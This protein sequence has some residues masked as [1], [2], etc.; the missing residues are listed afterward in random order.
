MV[1]SMSS[2]DPS[3]PAGA[4]LGAEPS[5]LRIQTQQTLAAGLYIVS[6][7]I[8]NLRDITLRALDILTNSDEILAEDTRTTRR[9]LDA[10]G[11]KAKLTPYHDHNGAERRP[12]ILDKLDAGQA[13]ALVSD[14]GTPLISDPGYKLVSAVRDAGHK[15]IPIPGASALLAALVSSGLPSDQFHFAGFPPQKTGAR[16]SFLQDLKSAQATL[17]FYESPRRLAA[18]LADM[19]GIL[20]DDRQCIVAR[21]LTK[22]FEE[23]RSGTLTSLAQHYEEA[24][25]PKGEVVLLVGP[26]LSQQSASQ[27]DI[28]DALRH[29][30]KSLPLKAAA[31]ELSERFKLPKRDLYQRGLTLKDQ[32]T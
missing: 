1:W 7:P 32:D 30:L 16:K 27:E 28:D 29:A 14:A 10:Y 11:I 23:V 5:Q 21:E 3:S 19:S 25:A 6:T 13:L 12:D 31:A 4:H 8:G 24:G 15:V 26:P 9:L 2:L 18:S 20:G 22:L 17:V